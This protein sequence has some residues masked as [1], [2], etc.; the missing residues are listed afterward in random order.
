MV[1]LVNQNPHARLINLYHAARD[2][3]EFFFLRLLGATDS[4]DAVPRHRHQR[5]VTRQH[6]NLAVNR[7]NSH[8]V[9]HL[10]QLDT[11]ERY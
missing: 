7:R 3:E 10:I 1:S 9:D 11:T 2:S 8:R 6:R 4:D 5:F